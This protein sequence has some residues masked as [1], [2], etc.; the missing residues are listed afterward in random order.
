[1]RSGHSLWLQEC[2]LKLLCYCCI[3]VP[4]F[5]SLPRL[6]LWYTLSWTHVRSCYWFMGLIFWILSYLFYPLSVSDCFL[7]CPACHRVHVRSARYTEH[8]RTDETPDRLAAR[9]IHQGNKRWALHTS[10]HTICWYLPTS[11]RGP[12]LTDTRTLYT[13]CPWL[14]VYQINH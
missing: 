8:Q 9:Q 12:T 13:Q 4:Q 14:T 1:M 10:S 6:C 2:A 3:P 7:P 5:Y 11:E